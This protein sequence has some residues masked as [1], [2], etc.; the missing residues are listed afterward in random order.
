MGVWSWLKGE[1]LLGQN[2]S[3]QRTL[4]RGYEAPVMS[5]TQTTAL[6]AVSE[7]SALKCADIFACTRVLANAIGSLPPRVYRRQADGSRVP[8]GDEQR[9]VRLLRRPE[10]GSTS[11]D[12]LG[13]IMLHL[14]VHG[15]A[16]IAK[17]REA[18][19]I[20]QLALLDPQAVTVERKGPRV[21]YKLSRREG[22]S[23]HDERD[24]LHVKA[25]SQ[26][27]L[28]GVSTVRAAAKVLQLNEGL[29]RY[30]T[31]WLGN[32]ARPGG[33]LW[34]RQPGRDAPQT[35]KDY[36][37]GEFG[38]GQPEAGARVEPSGHGHIA[39][40][41][42][43]GK[44]EGVDPA[45]SAQ[46]FVAQREL[47]AKECARAFGLPA[48]AVNAPTAD[49]LTY[50]TVEGQLRYLV[51]FSLRGWAVRIE[52]AFNGD[53]D[54]L[55]GGAYMALDFDAFLRGNIDQR[56]QYYE[57]ALKNGWLLVNEI[58]AAEDLP[59]LP[60]GDDPTSRNLVE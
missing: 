38:H 12:L 52:R 58:R 1:D 34:T 4:A 45:L 16:F 17:Y 13:S 29:I 59:P 49:S 35:T 50:S 19:E 15:D 36:L 2:G 44:Y 37:E 14:L 32:D 41:S 25:M 54:L 27:G 21:L 53:A 10:P 60:E 55:P 11:A 56:G 8:A 5:W 24:I 28:R 20:V 57:R 22:L 42:G 40:Y 43:E 26:D 3:E 39:V 30:V 47:A 46:E 9:L 48:W 18:G 51:D 7:T 6:P 23:E 33:I 31:S